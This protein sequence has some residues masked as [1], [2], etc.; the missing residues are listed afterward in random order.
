MQSKLKIVQTE[1]NTKSQRAKVEKKFIFTGDCEENAEADILRNGINID[2]DV[3]QVGHHGSS[4]SSKE[5]FLK[6]VLPRYAAI[7]VGKDN[8]YSH[9]HSEVLSSLEYVGAK[10]Y[11]TDLDGDITFYVKNKKIVPKTE[12]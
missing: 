6:A 5:N 8:S 3:Y 1:Q 9:P 2:A 11:R 7:S 10:L 12:K 4:T